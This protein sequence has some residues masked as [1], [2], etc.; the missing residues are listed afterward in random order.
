MKRQ[1]I[2]ELLEAAKPGDEASRR[3]DL[4]MIWLISL[5]VAGTV[6]RTVASLDR[7]WGPWFDMFEV[8]SVAVFTIEY[9]GRLWGCPEDRRYQRPIRGRLRFA[10]TFYALVDLAA[11]LP[12]YAVWLVPVDPESAHLFPMLRLF[13]LFKLMRY[14]SAFDILVAVVRTE[15]RTLM[16]TATIMI[17]LLLFSSSAMYVIEHRVQPDAF[18]SIPAAMW[19]GISTL[20]TVGYGDV[21]PVTP[22]G[23]FFGAVVTILGIGMFALPAGLL[24][25]GFAQEIKEREFIV[26]W[27]LV[28]AVPLFSRL[29]ALQIANIAKV[30][31]HRKVQ[32]GETIF[33]KGDPEDGIYFI[34]SGEVEVMLDPE[35]TRLRDTF[36]GEIA[37]IE[38]TIRTATTR[39]V[40]Q[41]QLLVLEKKHLERFFEDNSELRDI[42]KSVAGERLE[43]D[44]RRQAES[45]SESG[46]ASAKAP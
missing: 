46:P 30:L 22:L 34:V 18:A 43:R 7:A 13:R 9:L 4:A 33:E 29:N 41:A 14:S 12:F 6:L 26:T 42:V 39:A 5:N 35:P 24:A 36:F 16:T 27:N 8:V 40:T 23:R 28:A 1:R 15:K 20:T 31:Q 44:R 21:T 25:N 11:I 19:W 37:L 17:M 38:D 32:P 2:W 3:F 45:G 10:L